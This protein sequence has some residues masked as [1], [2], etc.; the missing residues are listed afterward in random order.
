MTAADGIGIDRL[1][2]GTQVEEVLEVLAGSAVR[3][4]PFPGRPFEHPTKLA[5]SPAQVED[6]CRRFQAMGLRRRRSARLPGDRGR[7]ARAGPRGPARQRRHLTGRRQRP[8]GGADPQSRRRRSGRVHNRV[9]GIRRLVRAASGIS[10]VSAESGAS[11]LRL[12]RENQCGGEYST[13]RARAIKTGR[14]SADNMTAAGGRNPTFK[15]FEHISACA[16]APAEFFQPHPG[17]VYGRD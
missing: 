4:L 7:S 6:D 5:G 1:L 12:T 15:I 3:Y 9:R 10:A 16:P 8:H 14:W 13:A 11:C 2:G 17:P